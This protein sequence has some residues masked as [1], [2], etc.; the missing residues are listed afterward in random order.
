RIR[1]LTRRLEI[2][3]IVQPQNS[4]DSS[5][6]RVRFG[7]YV[8]VADEEG[9]ERTYRIV[10]EDESRPKDGWVSWVSPVARALLNAQVG[11][12]VQFKTPEGA[13]ELE[14]LKIQYQP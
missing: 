2:A 5:S 6:T 11:D 12:V 13:R 10:G 3:E 14:I 1:F 9:V 7:A 4:K 8:W